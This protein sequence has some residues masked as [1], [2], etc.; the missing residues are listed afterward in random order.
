ME[1]DIKKSLQT[2]AYNW[3]FLKLLWCQDTFA[4]LKIIGDLEGHL[5]IKIL[6]TN[7]YHIWNQHR[8]FYLFANF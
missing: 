8:I 3:Q 6:P 5:F 4:L 1:S 2:I 7:I